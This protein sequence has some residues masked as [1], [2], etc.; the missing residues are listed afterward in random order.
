MS[1]F[2]GSVLYFSYKTFTF[3]F[4]ALEMAASKNTSSP[5]NTN[6][7]ADTS[8]CFLLRLR[9]CCHVVCRPVGSHV[10]TLLN[11]LVNLGNISWPWALSQIATLQT[12]PGSIKDTK[13]F[14]IHFLMFDTSWASSH[15]EE[16]PDNGA[17]ITLLM[18]S[19]VIKSLCF[20]QSS[21]SGVCWLQLLGGSWCIRWSRWPRSDPV[22]TSV[23]R[24]PI[25]SG[26]L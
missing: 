15:L 13:D 17:E 14:I 19:S 23:L 21:C 24:D 26:Q 8:S 4:I 9:K 10:V 20:P 2:S 16:R 18:K 25:T 5:R 1:P 3:A 11:D 12:S 22:L 6:I 7:W